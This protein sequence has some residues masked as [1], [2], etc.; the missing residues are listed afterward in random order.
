MQVLFIC[1][2]NI[3]R[4]KEWMVG[5]NGGIGFMAFKVHQTY[6]VGSLDF[7]EVKGYFT[8]K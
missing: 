6:I 7:A 5:I 1:V 4:I 3:E 8:S 2:H